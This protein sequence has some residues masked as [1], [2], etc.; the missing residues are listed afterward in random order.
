MPSMNAE[1]WT[2]TDVAAYLN[3]QV[4]TVSSYRHRGQMPAPD[5]TLGRTHLWRPSTIT[6]WRATG[7]EVKGAKTVTTL[8]RSDPSE[9]LVFGERDVYANKWVRL[10]LVD[11]EPPHADRFEHHVVTLQEAAMTAVLD[12]ERAHVALMWRH[13]FPTNSWNW[14]LPGGLVDPG[15]NPL[16]TAIREVEEEIG[17]RVSDLRHLVTFQPIIGMVRAA[18]HVFAACG[19][20]S[21]GEPTER[22]EMQRLEWIPLTRVPDLIRDGQIINS[23][24]LIALL[25]LLALGL[26]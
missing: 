12:D 23:G 6:A 13:R 21:M 19:Y 20:E 5:Q 24:T 7:A 10:S 11:V 15:E 2:T 25:H 4:G 1:W 26:E 17:L 22:N 3:V 8:E 14:E 18:H 9:W 16:E